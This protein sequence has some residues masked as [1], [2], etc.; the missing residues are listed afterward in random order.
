MI[1]VGA[2]DGKLR[3]NAGVIVA[4]IATPKMVRIPSLSGF[5][6]LSCTPNTAAVRLAK[7]GPNSHGK[8]S[9]SPK[10]STA[11]VMQIKCVFR[12]LMLVTVSLEAMGKRS[13]HMDA[14]HLRCLCRIAF[15]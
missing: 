11:P 7:S 5:H 14:H 1:N 6:V 10:K 8:G 12:M 2:S 3:K 4:P 13:L 9:P 15:L